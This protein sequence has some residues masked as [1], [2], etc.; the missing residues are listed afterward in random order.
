M[1]DS[2]EI[3]KYCPNYYNIVN[4]DFQENDLISEKLVNIYKS[5]VF[6]INVQN[7]EELE[8]VQELDRVLSNYIADYLFRSTLQ[9]E[10][11]TVRVKKDNNI[12]RNLVDIII[13]IFSNYEEYTTRKLYISK[14]I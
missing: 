14:W 9:K 12:I 7:D 5:Y 2:K 1:N 13:K 3:L 10:I 4:F 11:V 6:S 8:R